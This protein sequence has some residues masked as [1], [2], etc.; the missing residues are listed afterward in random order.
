MKKR[1]SAMLCAATA[2]GG[3]LALPTAAHAADPYPKGFSA[4]VFEESIKLSFNT[5]TP[6]AD[7]KVHLRKKGTPTRVATITS[8]TPSDNCWDGCEMPDSPVRSRS[9]SSTLKLAELGEYA[10]DVEY[11][12]T[13][14]ETV[15]H[16][17]KATMSYQLRP[18]FSSVDTSNWMSLA[19]LDTVVSGDIKIHDPRDGSLKPFAGGTVTRRIGTVATPVTADAQGHFESKVTLSGDEALHEDHIDYGLYH[20][21]IYLATELNGAKDEASAEAGVSHK[22]ARINRDSTKVTGAYG[23]RGKVG[24]TVDWQ[25]PDGT[26]KPVPAGMKIKVGSETVSTDSTPLRRVPPVPCGHQLDGRRGLSL[27]VRERPAGGGGHHGRNPPL[28]LQGR[29]GPV[30]DREREGPVRA[31]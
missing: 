7:L 15:L 23:T 17:D 22:R 10:V 24:G 20:L 21:H 27:A 25:T 30:Q 8:L 1:I 9:F 3:V 12:G 14:G 28:R 5:M 13:E 16:Q 11:D 19:K 18:V 6:P 29:S 2:M 26:Y 4:E 31:R